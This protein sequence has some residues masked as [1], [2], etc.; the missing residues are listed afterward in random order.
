MA[1]LSRCPHCHGVHRIEE[2]V[3]TLRNLI[4]GPDKVRCSKCD[5]RYIAGV[6]RYRVISDGL[7]W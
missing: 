3:P 2:H 4:F 7:L 6:P 1:Y 5:V